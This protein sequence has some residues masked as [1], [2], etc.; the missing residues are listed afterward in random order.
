MLKQ[1]PNNCDRVKPSQLCDGV[2]TGMILIIIKRKLQGESEGLAR[3][4]LA[5]A[6][7]R[8]PVANTPPPLNSLP[9]QTHLPIQ[10]KPTRSISISPP[11]CPLSLSLGPLPSA[12]C[13]LRA[14]PTLTASLSTTSPLSRPS[15]LCASARPSP[16]PPSSS[17]LHHRDIPPQPPPLD[18]R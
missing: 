6:P 18:T 1:Q 3:G 7:Y 16:P 8:Y 17:L 14:G 4:P 5:T 12:L 2:E 15:A 9:H 10:T 11:L 13:P